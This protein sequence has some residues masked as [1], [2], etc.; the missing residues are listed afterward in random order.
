MDD[1]REIK[2]KVFFSKR[3]ESDYCE[4]DEIMKKR[5]FLLGAKAVFSSVV[6]LLPIVHKVESCFGYVG[7]FCTKDKDFLCKVPQ[8][9]IGKQYNLECMNVGKKE[10][11]FFKFKANQSGF[12]YI[13]AKE[14]TN[15]TAVENSIDF[16]FHTV[17][18]VVRDES[19]NVVPIHLDY[20][21]M[22][23]M[24]EKEM[25]LYTKKGK[26]IAT[27]SKIPVSAILRTQGGFKFSA[28]EGVTYVLEVRPTLNSIDDCVNSSVSLF[29]R[30]L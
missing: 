4:K 29:M 23:S 8:L 26:D 19:M 1:V 18:L 17:T 10:A 21:V 30:Y 9:E 25:E 12:I 3:Q 24:P 5:S 7:R 28:K 22:N 27:Q 15:S 13:G 11:G 6:A 20:V 2:T 16:Y 14:C